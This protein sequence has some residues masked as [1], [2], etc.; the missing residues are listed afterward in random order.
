MNDDHSVGSGPVD[1]PHESEYDAGL[2]EHDPGV[3]Y[4][5]LLREIH[6]LYRVFLRRM[7]SAYGVSGAQFEV[8]RRLARAGGRSSTSALARALEVDPAA[9]TRIVA[10]LEKLELVSREDD[11]HD[12]RRRPVVL[13][14]RG[15]EMMVAF[16]ELMHAR[17]SRLA[18]SVDQASLEGAMRVLQAIRAAFDPD[19]TRGP[20]GSA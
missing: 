19:A 8:L 3:G 2:F 15:R 4:L 12:R 17:E 10:G 13:T 16:H 5:H 9:I 18:A 11:V 14:P 7:E 1:E 20:G 6:L